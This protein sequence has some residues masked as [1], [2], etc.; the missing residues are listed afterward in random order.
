MRCFWEGVDIVKTIS[1]CE[2]TNHV[3]IYRSIR[4]HIFTFTQF[5]NF[6]TT[7]KWFVNVFYDDISAGGVSGDISSGGKKIVNTAM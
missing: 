1:F 2:V 5:L 4:A 6:I 7:I 3:Y